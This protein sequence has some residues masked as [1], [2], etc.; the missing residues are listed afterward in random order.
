MYSS[1]T[2]QRAKLFYGKQ[3]THQNGAVIDIVGTHR[4]DDR[5][6]VVEEL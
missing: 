6:G 2:A 1:E 4:S 5:G 3:D